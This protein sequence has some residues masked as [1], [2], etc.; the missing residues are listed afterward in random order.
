M[1]RITLFAL[2]FVLVGAIVTYYFFERKIEYKSVAKVQSEKIIDGPVLW[3]LRTL[4]SIE[5]LTLKN[6]LHLSE[7]VVQDIQQL[8]NNKTLDFKTYDYFLTF[9]QEIKSLVSSPYLIDNEDDCPDKQGEII[10]PKHYKE[11]K[12]Y[13]Y[14]YQLNK[15]NHYRTQCP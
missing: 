9:S 6:E 10:F 3:I 7:T 12:P 4:D 13:I 1:K 15:K 2:I 14:I 11:R 8:E 5:I